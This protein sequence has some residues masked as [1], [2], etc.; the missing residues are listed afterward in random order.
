VEDRQP[1]RRHRRPVD[2]GDVL[3]ESVG[4]YQVQARRAAE[5]G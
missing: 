5:G 1:L 2:A 4:H 3:R